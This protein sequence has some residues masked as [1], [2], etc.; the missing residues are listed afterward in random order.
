MNRPRFR[1]KL[2]TAYCLA[3]T[4]PLAACG[5]TPPLER[6]LAESAAAASAAAS[7][8]TSAE[9]RTPTWAPRPLPPQEK[10]DDGRR[11]AP[12]LQPGSDLMIATPSA[13]G[14]ISGRGEAISLR[15]E[16]APVT[17]V[18]HAILGDLLKVDYA[19]VTPLSGE[20]SLHTQA[21]VPREQVLPLLESLLQAN[22]IAMVA[23][24]AGRYR[25]GKSDALKSSVPLPR[26]AGALAAGAGTVIVPLQY[27][28]ASEMADILRPVAS[29]EAL[30]RVDT[31]RNLLMLSG[32]R[33]QLDGWLEIIAT[34]DVD[35]LHGMSVGL[36]P[37]NNGSARDL[38][39]ELNALLGSSTVILERD[40]SASTAQAPASR[41]TANAS[42]GRSTPSQANNAQANRAAQRNQNGANATTDTEQAGPLAGLVRVM[43]I[44]RL[45]ALL[46]VTPRAH[47]LEQV[48]VWIERLDNPQDSD[49]DGQLYVYPVQNGSAQHLADLLNGLYGSGQIE[50]SSGSGVAN[51]LARSQ[52]S[53]G[54][55]FGSLGS[56]TS[57]FGGSG[58]GTTSAFGSGA[59][60]SGTAVTQVSL[61]QGQAIRV[62]A[63][64]HNNAL[65][66]HASRRDY[67]RIEAALRRLDVAPTQVLI[68]ASIVEVTLSDELKYGLQWYFQNSLRGGWT[69]QGQLSSTDS[70]AISNT[71]QGFFYSAINPAGSVRAVLNTLATRSLLNVLSNP[72]VMVQDNHT[73]TI[74]VGDQQPIRSSTTITDG[75]TTTSSI[76]YKDTGV[77]LAVTP[78]VNAGD[79]VSLD[80]N[81]AITD[82]GE[83]DSATGQRAF[84]QRQVVSRVSVRSGE[85]IVLGGLIRDNKTRGKQGIP[86]L[87]DLPVVGN[88]FGATTVSTVRTE[89]L[90]MITPR[91]IRSEQDVRDIGSEIRNR[92]QG[93]KSLQGE[94]RL[95]LGRLERVPEV[96]LAS[97]LPAPANGTLATPVEA[98]TAGTLAR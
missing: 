63:D 42:A 98:V 70:G 96:P 76:Q 61:G 7:A 52:G 19:L 88:L 81:Q 28:G 38:A 2:K 95:S 89:L 15:F 13:R 34:F 68:E 91:V 64:N 97:A 47:Y 66:I 86:V 5:T 67:R 73:A 30:L 56:G 31:V 48:R 41:N 50:S 14:Q 54:T 85:T 55:S 11:L 87:H 25:V 92:M 43:A 21:P 90:V 22:G 17:E 71:G 20:I 53:T 82:V 8:A 29:N 26:Q 84:N 51:G 40:S 24:A 37:L 58:T 18:V 10:P 32:S 83:E 65:L 6:S 35:F 69:G 44:E 80:V 46:V 3:L 12:T 72:T 39:Q 23:D 57:A 9:T 79:M 45:N 33:N 74:Q 27:I 78:S 49:A 1:M 60:V 4:L 16:Q 77:M 59:Q 93:L 62:V 36:F 94:A 75:G